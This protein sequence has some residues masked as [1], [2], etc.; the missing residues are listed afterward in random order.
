MN[1]LFSMDKRGANRDGR[2]GVD[3][4]WETESEH[5]KPKR[6]N[7]VSAAAPGA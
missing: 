3:G 1:K 4:R 2:P 5:R 7:R 6:P